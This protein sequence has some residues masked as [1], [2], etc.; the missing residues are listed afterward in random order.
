MPALSP[1]NPPWADASPLRWRSRLRRWRFTLS[2][3][4]DPW[5]R[6]ATPVA[7]PSLLKAA[8]ADW[9]GYFSGASTAKISAL[10][11]LCAWLEACRCCAD[12]ERGDGRDR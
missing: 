9:R 7:W 12:E 3:P 6:V 5:A 10:D 11:E 8:P 2:P 1:Q 4:A